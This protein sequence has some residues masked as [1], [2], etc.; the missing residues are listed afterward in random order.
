MITEHFYNDRHQLVID[1]NQHLVAHLTQAIHR[2]GQA[3][4]V[5]PG[6]KTP[7]PLFDLLAQQKLE[8]SHITL[9][10]TDE[11]WLASD[12]PDSNEALIRNH[13]LSKTPARF[14]SLYSGD[15]LPETGQKVIE[16]RLQTLDWPTDICLLGMGEDGHI[17]SLFADAPEFSQGIS[18]QNTALC[19]STRPPQAAHARMSLTLNALLNSREIILFIFGENKKN[20]YESARNNQKLPSLPIGHALHRSSVPVH[21]YWSA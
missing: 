14:I 4:L 13:I 19:L 7:V 10:L 12:H 16:K 6:G 11:R 21:I 9:L 1:L 17:A 8:W 18:A 2:R 15:P 5:L 20:I 3:S